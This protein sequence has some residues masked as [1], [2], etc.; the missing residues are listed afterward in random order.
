[1]GQMGHWQGCENE[2]DPSEL[3]SRAWNKVPGD[4]MAQCCT[5]L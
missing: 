3:A 1:M 2:A 4:F 5:T